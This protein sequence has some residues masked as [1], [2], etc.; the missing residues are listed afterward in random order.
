MLTDSEVEAAPEASLPLEGENTDDKP[1]Q[2]AARTRTIPNTNR[3]EFSCL[4]YQ[5][6]YLCP[7]R[8][9]HSNTSRKILCVSGDWW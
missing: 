3:Y 8:C 2:S 6:D 5:S 7:D 9:F 4:Q 1:K